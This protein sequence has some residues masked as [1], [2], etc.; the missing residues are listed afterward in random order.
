MHAAKPAAAIE[1]ATTGS[2]S[3]DPGTQRNIF[4]TPDLGLTPAFRSRYRTTTF[5]QHS[6]RLRTDE[7]R[8]HKTRSEA[9]YGGSQQEGRDGLL[10]VVA[11]KLDQERSA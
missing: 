9:T 7:V 4:L 10:R 6:D 8:E 2:L 11:N 1:Q 5:K 3:T